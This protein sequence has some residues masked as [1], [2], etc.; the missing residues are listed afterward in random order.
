MKEKIYK[1]SFAAALALTVFLGSIPAAYAE[2]PAEN[3]YTS[4]KDFITLNLY[5]YNGKINQRWAQEK[6]YPGFQW[7]GGAYDGSRGTGLY[8]VDAIDFGNSKITDYAYS[9]KNHGK[10]ST[11]TAVSNAGGEI[12]K[13][14]TSA[15]V[16]N[17]PIGMSRGQSVMAN[18]LVDGCPALADGTSLSWLF[19]ENEAVTK[20]NSE[21]IDG[22]FKQDEQSGT[23]SYDSR[24]N[25]AQYADNFFTRYE[26]VITPNFIV[27]P[28]G[29]FLPL[30]DIQTASPVSGIS[31]MADYIDSIQADLGD[32]STDTQ[33]SYMLDKYRENL[34]KAGMENDTAADVLRD[35]IS[36]G[37]NDSPGGLADIPQSHLDRLYNIDWDEDTNFFFGM[38]MSMNFMMPKNGYTGKNGDTPMVFSFSGDD[39][40]WVYVDGALF[41]DLSGIHRHVGGKIDFVNGTVSY[42]GLDEKTGDVN[43][44]AEPYASFSFTELFKAA[45]MEDT[46]LNSKGTFPDHSNHELKFYYME[47]GS[48]SSVCSINFNFPLLPQ[49]GALVGELP[50][51]TAAMDNDA[52]MAYLSIPRLELELP[53]LSRWSYEKLEQGP[54]RYSG[55]IAGGD[56]VILAHNSEFQFGGI[57]GLEIGDELIFTDSEGE[58]IRYVAAAHEQIE[59][60]EGEKLCSG[61]YELSLLTCTEDGIDRHIV[62]FKRA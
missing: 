61:A 6:K 39:D 13:L 38:D 16:T 22:L 23:Y 8:I 51:S 11:S 3:S 36:S 15:G 31:S 5:D 9:G 44:D 40:V 32:D 37:K 28:F 59:A 27:Y 14:D 60:W 2:S 45:G 4:T 20:L 24:E 17:R 62:R 10:S 57:S 42:Y 43:M 34:K 19:T 55:S 48:G 41:L 53:V 7:N 12:N 50:E 1:S 54:C 26:S 18:R 29:N 52:S 47:R 25:H 46:T 30:N 49:T 21:T 58:H 56:L 35:F 33:L